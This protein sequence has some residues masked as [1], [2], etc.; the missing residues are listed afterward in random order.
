MIVDA[1][2]RLNSTALAELVEPCVLSA[3]VAIV[4]ERVGRDAGGTKG[5][6]RGRDDNLIG[7]RGRRRS[8]GICVWRRRN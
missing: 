5:Q 7:F 3:R 1:A 6:V 4:P 2:P 8:R